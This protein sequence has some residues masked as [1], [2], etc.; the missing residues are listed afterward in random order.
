VSH[1]DLA[2]LDRDWRQMNRELA[3]SMKEEA[4]SLH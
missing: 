3:D 4:A 1:R 2:S